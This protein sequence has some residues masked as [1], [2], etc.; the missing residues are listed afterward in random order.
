MTKMGKRKHQQAKHFFQGQMEGQP[1]AE[2]L[3]QRPSAPRRRIGEIVELLNMLT[4]IKSKERNVVSGLDTWPFVAELPNGDFL[5]RHFPKAVIHD[6]SLDIDR[7]LKIYPGF[8]TVS[9]TD[10]GGRLVLKVTNRRVGK[11]EAA[12]LNA[13]L[14]LASQGLLTRVRKCQQCKRWFF[15]RFD[16]QHSCDVKCRVKFAQSSP[17][18]KQEHNEKRRKYYQMHKQSKKVRRG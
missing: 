11:A 4:R 10:I 8:L 9:R 2:W 16:T 6:L 17:E 18:W 12:A 3:Q 7:R 1:L 15:A 13:V 14:S 5:A